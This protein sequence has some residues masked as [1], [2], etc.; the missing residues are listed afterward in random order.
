MNS[1]R[2]DIYESFAHENNSR[3]LKASDDA[4]ILRSLSKGSKVEPS[5]P[6]PKASRPKL[7]SIL[8]SLLIALKRQPA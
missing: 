4:R 5:A 2:F 6:S 8:A 3:I 1:L 7:A